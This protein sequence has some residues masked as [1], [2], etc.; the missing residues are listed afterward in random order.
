VAAVSPEVGQQKRIERR[1]SDCL[2][3]EKARARAGF[4]PQ[5]QHALIGGM[6]A[7]L[8][9]IAVAAIGLACGGPSYKATEGAGSGG[10]AGARGGAG[11][12]GSATGGAVAG[13]AGAGDAGG[14]GGGAGAA[15]EAQ[16]P[17]DGPPDGGLGACATYPINGDWC[18]YEP[19]MTSEGTPAG[20]TVVDGDYDLVGIR[21]AGAVAG[22]ERR[23]IRLL[24]PGGLSQIQLA[25]QTDITGVVEFRWSASL[26]PVGT[27]LYMSTIFC[28]SNG[29]TPPLSYGY[30]ASGT[31][32]V[33]Y[34]RFQST[35]ELVF[36]YTYRRTC[37]RP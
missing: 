9:L 22:R 20:G 8:S 31:D 15:G 12:G 5:S 16:C 34:E 27:F 17:A 14:D 7:V 10:S 4:C 24:K 35:G 6:R 36:V 37:R 1:L 11:A 3:C 2:I 21:R 25:A 32:L 18:A 23:T 30:T 28:S 13:H 19:L 26:T 33:L 29:G